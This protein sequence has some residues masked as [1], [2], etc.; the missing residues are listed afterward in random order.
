MAGALGLVVLNAFSV[1][2]QSAGVT[3]RRTCTDELVVESNA[4]ARVARKAVTNL[5]QVMAASQ[6]GI[7]AASHARF[8]VH[9]ED[10]DNIVGTG[11]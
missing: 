10:Q 8:P 1:A 7:T 2:V 3:V 9:E 4:L 6:S 5:D 11:H